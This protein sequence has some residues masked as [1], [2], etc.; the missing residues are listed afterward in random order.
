MRACVRRLVHRRALAPSALVASSDSES[1]SEAEGA[2]EAES[3]SDMKCAALADAG[4]RVFHVRNADARNRVF[5]IRNAAPSSSADDNP[6][7]SG[8]ECVTIHSV[9]EEI[10]MSGL[11]E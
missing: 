10:F 7:F 3:K 2:S 1:S 9:S 6:C 8:E 4:N 11:V 5:H